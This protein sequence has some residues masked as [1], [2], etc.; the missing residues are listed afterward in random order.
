MILLSS[1]LIRMII[2]QLICNNSNAIV[3]V[4][5]HISS[6]ILHFFIFW[7]LKMVIYIGGKYKN[8][9]SQ[10]QTWNVKWKLDPEVGSVMNWSTTTTYQITFL[11]PTRSSRNH[12]EITLAQIFKLSSYISLRS[13]S[14]VS[15]QS[16]S[17]LS[18]VFLILSH[19]VGAQ[20]TL[21]VWA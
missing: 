12:S 10:F 9:Q 14:A 16:I 3:I 5:C 17:F 11:P 4:L 20:N 19:T 13:L 2:L 1:L 18:T 6:S 8:C 7:Y 15:K 21:L